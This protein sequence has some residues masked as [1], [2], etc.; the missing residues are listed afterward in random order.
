MGVIKYTDI[1]ETQAAL[2]GAAVVA[3]MGTLTFTY[4]PALHS[5]ISA[6]E[7]IELQNKTKQVESF[8]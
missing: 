2:N 8:K 4:I 7:F 5:T 6:N 1:T 3:G